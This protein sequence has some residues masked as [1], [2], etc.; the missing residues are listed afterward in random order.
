MDLK[1]IGRCLIAALFRDS[2]RGT[3][4]KPQNLSEDNRNSSLNSHHGNH[5]YITMSWHQ[6]AANCN[7]GS[8]SCCVF[9]NSVNISDW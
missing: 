4:E 8:F 9:C 2:P 3:Q 5:L 7:N 1:G 6:S